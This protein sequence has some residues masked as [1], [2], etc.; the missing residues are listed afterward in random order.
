MH[1]FITATGCIVG[2]QNITYSTYQVPLRGS[3]LQA[4]WNKQAI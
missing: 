3:G 2:L 1:V 4:H